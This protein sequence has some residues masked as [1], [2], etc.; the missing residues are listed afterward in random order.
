MNMRV[1]NKKCATRFN[2]KLKSCGFKGIIISLLRVKKNFKFEF[3]LKSY[4]QLCLH[5]EICNFSNTANRVYV[6]CLLASRIF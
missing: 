1:C 4:G 2:I 6:G 5:G 3:S